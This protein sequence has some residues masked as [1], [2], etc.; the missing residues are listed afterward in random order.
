MEE[1]KETRLTLVDEEGTVCERY[2]IK[3]KESIQDDGRTLKLFI[4]ER[5]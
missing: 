2:N 5:E 1:R 3:I 4:E